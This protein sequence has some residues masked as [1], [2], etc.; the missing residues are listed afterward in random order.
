MVTSSFVWH[1]L[2]PAYNFLARSLLHKTLPEMQPQ[3]ILVYLC[4]S[5]NFIPNL[6]RIYLRE[7]RMANFSGGDT[8]LISK[9]LSPMTP[10][11]VVLKPYYTQHRDGQI[12]NGRNKVTSSASSVTAVVFHGDEIASCGISDW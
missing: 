2:L 11:T 4:R 12:Q 5:Y 9:T 10:L 3:Y 1:R 6:L 8:L 7:C